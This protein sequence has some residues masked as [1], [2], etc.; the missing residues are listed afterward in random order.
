MVDL[1]ACAVDS[2]GGLGLGGDMLNS[3][4]CT[5]DVVNSG[6]ETPMDA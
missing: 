1:R 3:G 6:G 4:G 5:V 2:G